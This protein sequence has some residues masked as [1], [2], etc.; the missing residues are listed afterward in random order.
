MGFIL[1]V[2]KSP[3][4]LGRVAG[5]KG[6]LR[7]TFGAFTAKASGRIRLS[8]PRLALWFVEKRPKLFQTNEPKF[9]VNL[10][11]GRRVIPANDAQML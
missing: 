8:Q 2:T 7:R 4:R 6:Q 3:T 10:E 9:S 5:K 1:W 11:L